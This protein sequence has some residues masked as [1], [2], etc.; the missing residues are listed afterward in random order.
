MSA[1]HCRVKVQQLVEGVYDYDEPLAA[2]VYFVDDGRKKQIPRDQIIIL[3]EQFTG[4][5]HQVVCF[6]TFLFLFTY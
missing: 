1:V 4:I 5:P 6:N 3:P 2:K